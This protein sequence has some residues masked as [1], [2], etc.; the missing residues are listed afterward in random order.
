MIFNFRD[1]D[2]R[3]VK[4]I[5]RLLKKNI[6]LLVM[7]IYEKS[8]EYFGFYKYNLFINNCEYF[9]IFCVIGRMYSLQVVDFG[10]CSLL[11]YIKD[12]LKKKFGISEEN[13]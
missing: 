8:I 10:F 3:V 4:Y 7:Q 2:V 5:D 11:L 1:E 9:V 6:V 13:E 12:R